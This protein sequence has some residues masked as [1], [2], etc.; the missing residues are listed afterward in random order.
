MGTRLLHATFLVVRVMALCP[1]ELVWDGLVLQQL[2][3]IYAD[4]K[5]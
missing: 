3:A 2:I 4:G 5:T 1:P